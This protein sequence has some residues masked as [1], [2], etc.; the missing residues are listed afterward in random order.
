ML[1]SSKGAIVC[2]LTLDLTLLLGDEAQ[3]DSTIESARSSPGKK[4]LIR[5]S[6]KWLNTSRLRSEVLFGIVYVEMN[7][8]CAA[9]SDLSLM[10]VALAHPPRL[11][12]F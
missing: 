6:N 2:L 8:F 11:Q 12:I 7:R 1:A 9:R 5:F 4:N 3:P 10:D